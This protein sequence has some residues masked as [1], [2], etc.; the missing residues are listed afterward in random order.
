MGGAQGVGER[1]SGVG[2]GQQ[3]LYSLTRKRDREAKWR[4]G[5]DQIAHTLYAAPYQTAKKRGV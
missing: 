3:M 2:I 4:K 5:F 1:A